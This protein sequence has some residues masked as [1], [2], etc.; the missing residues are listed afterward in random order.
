M[1]IEIN[2]LKL[3]IILIISI[4][5]IFISTYFTKVSPFTYFS[6]DPTAN[7]TVSS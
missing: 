4:I 6:V 7:N 1:L 2:I 5:I 3:S